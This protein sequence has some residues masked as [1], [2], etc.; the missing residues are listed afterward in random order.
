MVPPPGYLARSAE[1]CRAH[2]VLLCDEVQTGLGRTGRLPSALALSSWLRYAVPIR[3]GN[4]K[5]LAP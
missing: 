5:P 4:A 2:R 3:I 1:S